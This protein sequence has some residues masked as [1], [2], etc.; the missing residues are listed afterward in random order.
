MRDFYFHVIVPALSQCSQLTKA[1]FYQNNISLLILKNLLCHTA[2]LSKVAHELY[3]TPMECY[4]SRT[5]IRDRFMQVCFELLNIPC[6]RKCP[7][8]KRKKRIGTLEM[9]QTPE[10][11]KFEFETK[12]LW[13][14]MCDV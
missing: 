5:T 3:P 8:K 12:R 14:K 9:F 10:R 13:L 1:N 7:P 6:L 11:G 4:D 2:K